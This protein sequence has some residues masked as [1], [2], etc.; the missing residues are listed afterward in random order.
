M[1][2]TARARHLLAAI[3]G[4]FGMG[5][6]G[7]A[8]RIIALLS[9]LVLSVGPFQAASGSGLIIT[10]TVRDAVAVVLSGATVSDGRQ[11]VFTDSQG[12]YQLIETNLATYYVTASKGG[13]VAQTHAV[14]TTNN[15]EDVDFDLKFVVTTSVS[16]KY[17]NSVPMT[18]TVSALSLAPADTEF[19][20]VLPD[21]TSV[22]MSYSGQSGTQNAWQGSF[23]VGLSTRQALGP[24]GV[25]SRTL[26]GH[27]SR[28]PLHPMNQLWRKPNICS[29]GRIQCT[30]EDAA[31]RVRCSL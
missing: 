9:L 27:T 16:P 31:M 12:R 5:V 6:R 19:V 14:N 26:A 11:S 10:G 20:T 24:G 23:T 18:I 7:A 15:V 30:S 17:F 28:T 21:S 8:P 22:A 2:A 29:I 25:A 1:K 13:Y 3:E 4:L